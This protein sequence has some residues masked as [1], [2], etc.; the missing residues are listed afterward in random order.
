VTDT[1]GD[2][3]TI[4]STVVHT[5]ECLLH[6]GNFS[7]DDPDWVIKIA[8]SMLGHF[9][10][11]THPFNQQPAAYEISD[12]ARLVVVGDWGT[13]LPRARS[14][15]AYMA[16]AVAEGLDDRRDVHVIHLG[17]VYYSGLD[18]EYQRRVLSYW[19]VIPAQAEAGVTS[20]SLN[21]NHDMYS[22]GF[23]YFDTLL[24]DARFQHQKSPDGRATSYFHLFSRSWNFV[25]LD[26]AWDSRRLWKGNVGVLNDPQAEFVAAIARP[27]DKKLALFSHHQYLSVYSPDDLGEELGNKLAPV[28]DNGLVTAWWWGHEH[29]CMGFLPTGG[30]RYPRCLRSA[31]IP[32]SPCRCRPASRQDQDSTMSWFP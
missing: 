6:P 11:G 17:D 28:L 14:V 4:W 2:N 18:V 32:E 9:L 26:T 15:A 29:R 16:D 10:K 5:A 7:P 19:P 20:W 22:G 31:P 23:G 1:A 8:K 25:G 24:A 13:G 3:K 12:R 30:V 21:G 27:R